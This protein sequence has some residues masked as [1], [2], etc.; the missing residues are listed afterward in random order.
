M[1]RNMS[2]PKTVIIMSKAAY[3]AVLPEPERSAIHELLDVVDILHPGDPGT[4]GEHPEWTDVEFIVSGW[5][6]PVLTSELLAGL[7]TLVAIF[8]AAGT[9]KSIATGAI[10]R[11]GIRMTSAAQ[12]NA[13]PVAEYTC[14]QI[15]LALKRV[16]PRAMAWRQERR[17]LADDPHA[18]GALNSTIGLLAL[19]RTGRLVRELLRSYDLRVMVYDPTVS[20]EEAVT[21]GVELAPLERIFAEAHVVSC[22]LPLLAATT[23]ML[24]ARHFAAMRCGATFINTARARVLRETELLGVL[25]ERPDLW[26]ILDVTAPEPP[27]PDSPLLNL[28]NVILTPHLAGSQ[29][30]ECRRLGRAIIDE[31]KRHMGGQ[32][33]HGE[34]TQKHLAVIA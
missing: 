16:W 14:A 2:K 24:R 30:E 18:P 3:T 5:G 19:S 11:R 22:H 33:L 34:V 20:A 15:I 21:L 12:A 9:V 26:A 25:K 10:W 28:S 29:G 8:H 1:M 6:A 7:P 32:P 13:R 27:D 31:I 17:Y 4:L 23:G